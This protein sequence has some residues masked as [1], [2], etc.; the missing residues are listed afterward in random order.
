MRVT[1][2]SAKCAFGTEM[3]VD[4]PEFPPL[5]NL[6]TV[7]VS[8]GPDH[9][10]EICRLQFA[11]DADDTLVRMDCGKAVEYSSARRRA[12]D[13]PDISEQFEPK[14]IGLK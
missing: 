6:G 8:I 2:R 9:A 4:G 7:R 11:M 13:E 3:P 14:I 10:L 1:F 5:V 12:F